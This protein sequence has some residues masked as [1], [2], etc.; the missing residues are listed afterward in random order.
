R[1]VDREDGA[2]CARPVD[3]RRRD[4]GHAGGNRKADARLIVCEGRKRKSAML[5][6]LSS[7]IITASPLFQE[8]RAHYDGLIQELRAA[9]AH[10]LAGGGETHVNRHHKRGK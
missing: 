1:E 10:S 3:R 8:N 5:P 9:L 6:T 2:R 7:N 4:R